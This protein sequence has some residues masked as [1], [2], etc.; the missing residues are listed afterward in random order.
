MSENKEVMVWVGGKYTLKKGET[1][2]SVMKE[3]N[4]DNLYLELNFTKITDLEGNT[5]KEEKI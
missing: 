3:Y 2:D 5:L 4:K 1:I